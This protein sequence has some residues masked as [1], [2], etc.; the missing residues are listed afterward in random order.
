[1][2][3][4]LWPASMICVFFIFK[5][6]T[7]SQ[8]SCSVLGS[9]QLPLDWSQQWLE[10]VGLLDFA[11]RSRRASI[12]CGVDCDFYHVKSSR[13]VMFLCKFSVRVPPSATS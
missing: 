1:M 10:S 13:L 9:R 8:E 6:L 7:E 2:D 5:Q 4:C 12:H 3:A 11:L